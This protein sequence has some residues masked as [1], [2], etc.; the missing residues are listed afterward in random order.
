MACQFVCV[1]CV[2]EKGMIFMQLQ[3]GFLL[4][5]ETKRGSYQA[6]GLVVTVRSNTEVQGFNFSASPVPLRWNISG[7]SLSRFCL[8]GLLLNYLI[9][10]VIHIILQFTSK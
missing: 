10:W 7:G 1:L 6:G 8:M 3:N 2:F 5:Q 4:F 9:T